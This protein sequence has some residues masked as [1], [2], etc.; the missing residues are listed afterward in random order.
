M[1][2]RH[3]FSLVSIAGLGALSAC[4]DN[5]TM[6]G[7]KTSASIA[8]RAV[9]ADGL[10]HHVK[11]L[12]WNTPL[13]HDVSASAVIGK[14]GGTIR[15]GEM[16]VVFSVPEGALHQRT[17]ITVTALAGRHV[18]FTMTPHGTQFRIPATLTMSLA[19]TNAYHQTSWR[20]LLEAGYIESPIQIGEDDGVDTYEDI[21]PIVDAEVTTISFPMSHFSV[22][23]LAS[24][25]GDPGPGNGGPIHHSAGAE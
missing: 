1:N 8:A 14:T 22:V 17:L 12:R 13:K 2:A 23:I 9:A 16:N 6:L 7:P 21:A 19:G 20:T 10:G 5:S 3:L 4:G 24:Q 25:I 15:L 18:V 11:T